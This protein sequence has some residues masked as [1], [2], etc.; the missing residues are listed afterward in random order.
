MKKN[1]FSVQDLTSDRDS[2]VILTLCVIIYGLAFT[3]FVF[4]LLFVAALFT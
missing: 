3:V 4:G 1:E 2:K